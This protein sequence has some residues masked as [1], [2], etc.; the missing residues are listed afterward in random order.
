MN[1]NIIYNEDGTEMNIL[2][3]RKKD[4]IEYLQRSIRNKNT[5]I[6]DFYKDH[7][8]IVRE[9]GKYLNLSIKEMEDTLSSNLL[10][11]QGAV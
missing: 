3:Q 6:Y 7:L 5:N 4:F 9:Y 8:A 2:E 10:M 1:S 11:E